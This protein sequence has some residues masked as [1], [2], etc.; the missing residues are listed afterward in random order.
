MNRFDEIIASRRSI[1]HFDAARPVE[2]EEIEQM[3]AASIEAPSWKNSQTARYHV[4]Q[5]PEMTARLREALAP[6]NQISAAGASALI[7]TTFVSNRSGFERSGEPTNELGNG[8]GIYDL[9]LH[10]AFL[11]LKAAD[12]GIDTI[13][14]G[15]RDA[16]KVRSALQIPSEETVVSVI[17]VGHRSEDALRPKRKTTQE[18]AKFY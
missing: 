2:S 3:I 13:V 17:A 1:R 15:L 9:G 18:I 12:L 5:S 7:V 14:L 10:D 8:W 11:L 4:V 16:E 6:Q